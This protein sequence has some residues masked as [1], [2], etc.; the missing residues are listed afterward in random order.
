MYHADD[1]KL[2]VTFPQFRPTDEYGRIAQ[3][4]RTDFHTGDAGTAWDRATERRYIEGGKKRAREAGHDAKMTLQYKDVKY[5]H[6]ESNDN[7]KNE[8]FS[9]IYDDVS[10]QGIFR[11][12]ELYYNIKTYKGH[13]VAACTKFGQFFFFDPLRL[14][15]FP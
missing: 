4:R 11:G 5:V 14:A 2:M 12:N 6:T 10:L 8:L 1:G 9:F 7:W 15:R 13:A 3:Q